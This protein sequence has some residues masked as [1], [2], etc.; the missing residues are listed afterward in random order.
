MKWCWIAV[1]AS[2][3][4]GFR[5]AGSSGDGGAGDVAD[6]GHI[7]PDAMEPDAPDAPALCSTWHPRHFDPCMIGTPK[8]AL[9]ITAAASPWT[10]DTNST[11]GQ[12]R[13]NTG[14]VLMSNL[15]VQQADG[16]S[17]AVLNVDNLTVE[18]SA[19]LRVTGDRPLLIA[20]W[21]AI[22][23]AG[24][25]DA[26][27]VTAEINNT[28]N[29]HIDGPQ[30]T[31]A[32]ANP[33]GRCTGLTNSA[34]APAIATG[35]SGGGGGAG[36][37]GAGGAGTTGDLPNAQAGGPGGMKVSTAPTT[38]R[39]GCPGAA[40]GNAGTSTGLQTPATNQSVSVG[41]AGGGAI[42]LSARLALTSPG[43]ITAGGAGG[44]GSPQGSAVGGGGGGAGGYIGLEAP[45]LTISG[46]LA[47]NGGGGGGAA[48][49]AANGNQ[50]Q[51]A[52]NAAQAAG[53]AAQ[54]GGNCGLA[55]AAGSVGAT[56]DAPSAVGSDSCGG[57]GGGGGAGFIF[58]WS[59]VL[60]TPGAV[61]S[62]PP[63]S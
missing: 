12:L 51:N 3:G 22:T 60:T 26:G 54:G 39:G 34:G 14:V 63:K 38:L 11:G 27:S 50:G 29:A 37:Q 24:T 5:V 16:S 17:I 10:F 1:L 46:V 8:P 52:V 56:L 45:T 33:T 41:G 61:I 9:V 19:V 35:G 32:G 36:F 30:R 13:D 59:P 55:G 4:C 28:A 49:Y 40:S 15:L 7:D 53:G 62:P 6:V 43:V 48:G 42:E 25:I 58:L 23:I 21:N 31:G 57:G 18:S 20:S 2:G 47:A 44:A